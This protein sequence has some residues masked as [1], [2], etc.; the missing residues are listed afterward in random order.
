[1]DIKPRPNHALYLD[2]L[3]RMPAEKKLEK[4]FELNDLAK[5]LCLQGLRLGHP[6]CTEHELAKLYVKT[7]EPCHNRN[8]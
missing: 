6:D 2:I 3:R 8:Y 7:I 5:E 4:V 1:M